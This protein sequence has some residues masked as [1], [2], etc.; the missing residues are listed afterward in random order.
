MT[1]KKKITKKKATKKTALSKRV[2]EDREYRKKLIE[3]SKKTPSIGRPSE[4]DPS[5]CKIALEGMARGLSKDAVAGLLKISRETLYRWIKQNEE[6]R[7]TI[8]EGET[9]SL[10]WWEQKAIDTITHTK[11]SKQLNSTSW[12]F[13]M[14]NRHG[15]K[16]K[17]EISL[18]D[19]TKKSFG[20]KLDEDPNEVDN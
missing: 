5:F 20:F 18:E 9:L 8:K 3:E 16:D 6:F 2:N 15:W 10:L 12:I 19:E 14:K 1:V 7:D 4:Y 17:Q 11:N 13:N